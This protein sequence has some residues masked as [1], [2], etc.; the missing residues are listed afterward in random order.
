MK[1]P[2]TV[3]REV[4]SGK[5]S[6]GAARRST[7]SPLSAPRVISGYAVDRRRIHR[8]APC[9]IEGDEPPALPGV[10]REASSFLGLGTGEQAGLIRTAVQIFGLIEAMGGCK[11][12]REVVAER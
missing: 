10:S 8:T 12:A 1:I 4:C 3:A 11:N 6:N 7:R 2:Q 9:C 5:T